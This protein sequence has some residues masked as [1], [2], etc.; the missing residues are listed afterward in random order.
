MVEAR[1]S[2]IKPVAYGV[3][4]T[5]A[6]AA[7]GDRLLAIRTELAAVIGRF[8]P[9]AAAVEALFFAKNVSTAI[10]VAHGRG[11]IMLG[12]AEAG[13]PVAEYSPPVVKKAVTGSGAADKAQMQEMVRRLLGLDEPPR[14]DDAADALAV[15][16]CHAQGAGLAK[17]LA[18]AAAKPKPA[19]KA[20]R[21]S[22]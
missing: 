10:H 5:P 18:K 20:G 15:A 17:A 13:L 1:G 3:I 22:T 11:V 8:A 16:I 19:V 12:L 14:P 9:E 21:G 6:G 2:R 4:E 7:L